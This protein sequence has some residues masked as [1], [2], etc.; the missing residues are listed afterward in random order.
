MA[1]P[2]SKSNFEGNQAMTRHALSLVLVSA[3]LSNVSQANDIVDFLRAISGPS[4]SAPQHIPSR[5]AYRPAGPFDSNFIQP[6]PAYTGG[7]HP[8]DLSRFQGLR[9]PQRSQFSVSFNTAPAVPQ[10]IHAP[11][12][13][14]APAPGSFVHLPH[15]IGNIVTCPV[16]V[17]TCVRVRNTHKIAPLAVPVV[18]A[19]RDPNLGRFRSCVEQLVY[20][21]VCVP[22]CPLRSVRVSPCK[23]KFRMDYGK[24]EVDV[25][26]RNGRIDVIYR[27]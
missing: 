17:T 19:V 2:F 16:P 27:D 23:T 7:R 3:V 18:V 4:Y 8:H 11:P 6:Q 24:Y 22:Q 13:P 10:A 1:K 25:I 20:V 26:S 5:H 9:S 14:A 12:L 21:E 15:Q